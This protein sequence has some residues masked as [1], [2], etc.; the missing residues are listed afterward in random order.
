MH[1]SGHWT[2]EAARTSQFAN[3]VRAALEL[4]IGSTQLACPAVMC[5]VLGAMPPPASLL[6]L[7]LTALH[8]YGKAPRAGRKVGHVTQLVPDGDL[9]AAATA[10]HERVHDSR[11]TVTTTA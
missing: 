11:P 8:D 3:H 1:N 6:E 5:N 7:P 4:P 9:I 10:L 2:I